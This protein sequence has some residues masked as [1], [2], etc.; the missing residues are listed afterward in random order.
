ML[1]A[2]K[3]GPAVTTP[4]SFSPSTVPDMGEHRRKSGGL[5]LKSEL[6]FIVSGEEMEKS[7]DV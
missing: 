3:W 2:G 6:S 7:R 1:D 5:Y 4:V